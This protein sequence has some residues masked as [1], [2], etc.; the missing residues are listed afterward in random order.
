MTKMTQSSPTC[1]LNL[2]GSEFNA[3]SNRPNI[4]QIKGMDTPVILDPITPMLIETASDEFAMENN[5]VI[6]AVSF[7]FTFTSV[8][9]L[10][11]GSLPDSCFVVFDDMSEPVDCIQIINYVSNYIFYEMP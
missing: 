9:D 10:V 11:D 5:S 7:L 6:V 3:S 1:C 4:M 2:S 8:N